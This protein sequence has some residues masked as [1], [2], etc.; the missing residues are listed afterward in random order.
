VNVLPSTTKLESIPTAPAAPPPPIV[1]GKFPQTD[2]VSCL[3][4]PAPPPP[5]SPP[6]PP[7]TRAAV[8]N[9]VPDWILTVPVPVCCVILFLP[10]EAQLATPIDPPEAVLSFESLFIPAMGYPPVAFQED[11]SGSHSN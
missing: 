5:L 4:P 6:P 1:A 7:P 2:N 10:K 3:N 11:V 8:I 9:F